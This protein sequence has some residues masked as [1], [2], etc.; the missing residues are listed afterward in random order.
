MKG[1]V[2]KGLS[3]IDE[4]F[5]V[6]FLPN[7][8]LFIQLGK[9]GLTCSVL[10]SM[11]NKFIAF[12]NYTFHPFHNY[13]ALAEGIQQLVKEDNLVSKCIRAKII[14]LI[15]V[16]NKSTIIP[17]ALFESTNKDAYLKFNHLFENDMVISDDSL[18]I[19]DAKN[20]YAIPSII[21]KTLKN[22]FGNISI[23][24]YSTPLIESLLSNHKNEAGKKIFVHVQVD[25]L[26]IIVAEGKKLLFYNSFSYQTGEDFIY[27]VLFVAEQ[28]KLNPGQMYLTVVGEVDKDS[29][30][31]L[32]LFKYV[33]EV[34]FGERPAEHEYSYKL[35]TLPRHYYYNLFS[36]NI[37]ADN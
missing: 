28:L 33:H 2:F 19:P 4:T 7:Y 15:W 37:L 34:K 26:E 13:N 30:L 24:H 12:E 16:E 29:A 5:D 11:R 27:Y 25:H 36:L 10:D 21:D 6:K 18:N 35:D 17:N 14:K 20:I 31:Y 8:H 22:I 1:K 9:E 23:H 32:M 3:L